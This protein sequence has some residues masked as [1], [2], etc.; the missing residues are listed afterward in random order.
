MAKN[1]QGYKDFSTLHKSM[2]LNEIE[3]YRR[4]LAKRA[5]QRLRTLEKAGVKTS[6]MEAVTWLK[7]KGKT[8]FKETANT[9]DYNELKSEVTQLSN[10][11]GSWGSTLSGRKKTLNKIKNTF[12]NKGFDL[13]DKALETLLDNFDKIKGSNIRYDVVLSNILAV[14]DKKTSAQ[15]IEEL[16]KLSESDRLKTEKG[17]QRKIDTYVKGKKSKGINKRSKQ[18]L[19]EARTA[20][21]KKV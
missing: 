12:K 14:T 6:E 7:K 11:L 13:N 3:T 17:L 10:F 1:N 9:P 18:K 16:I 20:I 2:S 15:E 4:T 21:F 19:N 8:R 5:N